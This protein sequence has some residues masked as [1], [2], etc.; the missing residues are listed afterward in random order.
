MKTDTTLH[1]PDGEIPPCSSLPVHFPDPGEIFE[2]KMGVGYSTLDE[3]GGLKMV[4]IMNYLQDAAS[5]HAHQ[6]GIS[7]RHLATKGVGWV[8][9]RY[10]I[11]L[12][13]FPE[14][15][16]T[17]TVRTF[18]KPYNNL[19]DLRYILLESSNPVALMIQAAGAW[20]MVNR[21]TGRPVR[22]KRF[23]PPFMLEG[24]QATEGF[25]PPPDAPGRVDAERHFKVR[26]HDL[27]LNAHVNNAIHV[28][29]AVETLPERLDDRYRP[30]FV[31]I[32]YRRPAYYG[33]A[34]VSK[35]T[36]HKGGDRPVTTHGIYR[37][38]DQQLLSCAHIKWVDRHEQRI[39][40]E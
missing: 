16:D 21:E 11:T 40:T 7:G 22:L 28:E 36:V 3:H 15:L 13:S 19:Y 32:R 18:R 1:I 31:D 6:M 33:D 24:T 27:D 5:E 34:I 2:K 4:S 30:Q 23:L 9:Q 29:W 10:Q 25:G 37:L 35:T 20:V 8:I 12:H 39:A 26:R 38:S 14:W 17:V